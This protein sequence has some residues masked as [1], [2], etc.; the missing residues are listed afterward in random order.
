MG[1]LSLHYQYGYLEKTLLDFGFSQSC[2][3]VAHISSP[4]IFFLSIQC[5]HLLTRQSKLDTDSSQLKTLS[6]HPTAFANASYTANGLTLFQNLES[7]QKLQ[8]F[9]AETNPPY[10]SFMH[11]CSLVYCSGNTLTLDPHQTSTNVCAY[12]HKHAC[13]T[14]THKHSLAA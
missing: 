13:M 6:G 7:Q 8:T 10:T 2:S 9:S 5:L 14:R 4:Q 11:C 3:C 1:K 12:T